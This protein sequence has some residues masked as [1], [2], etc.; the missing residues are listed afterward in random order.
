MLGEWLICLNRKG[1]L[2]SKVLGA[3]EVNTRELRSDILRCAGD[4]V[5]KRKEGKAQSIRVTPL[6]PFL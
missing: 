2:P 1:V 5:I 3:Q 6:N 4:H